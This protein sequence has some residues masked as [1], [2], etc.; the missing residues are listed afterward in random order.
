[1]RACPSG[2]FAAVDISTPM[3]R[4]RSACCAPAASGHAAA[5]PKSVMNLRRLI[6]SLSPRV[7][8]YHIVVAMPSCASQQ[9]WR[10]NGR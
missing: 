2:S 8:P 9:N 1:M 4:M 3:R 10:G 5:P 7:P 6:G